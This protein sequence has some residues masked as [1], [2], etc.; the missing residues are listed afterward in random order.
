MGSSIYSSIGLKVVGQLLNSLTSNLSGPTSS[1]HVKCIRAG[2]PWPLGSKIHL[3]FP[4]HGLLPLSNLL[5]P[6]IPFPWHHS[7]PS[8]PP[9]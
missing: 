2:W 7:L 6:S 3:R 1:F 9:T 8:H 4:S 5:E